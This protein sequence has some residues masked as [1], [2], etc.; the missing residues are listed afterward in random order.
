MMRRN[1]AQVERLVVDVKD[2]ARL[3]ARALRVDLKACDLTAL[4]RVPLPLSSRRPT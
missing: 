3:E 1:L 4:A 2:L